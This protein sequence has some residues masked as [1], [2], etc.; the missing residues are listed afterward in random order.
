MAITSVQKLAARRR[1]RERDHELDLVQGAIALV[2]AGG[3]E[4][5]ALVLRHG[6]RI[7]PAAQASGRDHHV[8]VR[9]ARREGGACDLVVEPMV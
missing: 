1:Q 2:A 4:R 9:V 5:V 7:L 8:E 6:E 3:A